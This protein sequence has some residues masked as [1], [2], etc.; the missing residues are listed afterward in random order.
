MWKLIFSS[1]VQ[2]PTRTCVSIFA[3]ALGVVLILVSVGLS[4]G[5]L[6]DTANRTKRI[7]GDF[8][9]QP[10]DAS[11]FFALSSGTLPVKL[12]KVIELVEG[13]EAAT[14]VLVKFI[15][16]KF[17]MVHGIDRESFPKVNQT[18]EV[19]A[20]SMFQAPD[21]VIVDNIYS[22]SQES[23][24]GNRLDLLGSPFTISGIFR[25]G[26]AAR[27]LMPLATLQELNGTPDKASVFFIRARAGEPLEMV[28]EKLNARFQHYKITPTAQLHELM[29]ANA[30]GFKQF[31]TVIVSVSTVVSFLIILLAMYSTIIERTREI[32]I[33]KSLGASK[34]YIARL[35]LKESLLI[36]AIGVVVGMS[37]TSLTVAAIGAAFP[38]L[39][40]L[41]TPVWLVLATLMAIAGGTLGAV[42]PTLQ[43][44][45][46]DPVAALGYE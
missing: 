29:T 34:S 14:P 39:Q 13:V 5:Q 2:R 12:Q 45:K 8:I 20:G 3:I 1:L 9:L 17:H 43:A 32:G 16:E 35:M 7:G 19:I 21:E 44:A 30:P 27:V 46:L 25:A 24:L 41:I 18:L 26:T 42:Y 36:C 31:L 28:E 15:G 6:M 10:P 11:L 33:L 23:G 22:Q 38:G 4:Y 40:V 37:L